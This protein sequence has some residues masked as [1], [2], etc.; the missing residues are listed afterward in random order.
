MTVSRAKFLISAVGVLSAYV[1][2]LGGLTWFE[3][4]DLPSVLAWA[5]GLAGAAACS[6][7][8]MWAARRW[9]GAAAAHAR[10]DRIL[11]FWAAAFVAAYAVDAFTSRAFD[12]ALPPSVT[13]ILLWLAGAAAV[14]I[15][16]PKAPTP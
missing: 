3:G 16:E 1:G 6:V 8:A 12:V 11:S 15:D 2:A 9:A 14:W 5:F 13:T 4:R 10:L 7:L